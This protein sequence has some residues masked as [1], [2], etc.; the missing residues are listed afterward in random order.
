MVPYQ[1]FVPLKWFVV[2]HHQMPEYFDVSI[3]VPCADPSIPYCPNTTWYSTTWTQMFPTDNWLLPKWHLFQ[4]E[5]PDHKNNY[6]QSPR[7]IHRHEW[8]TS[9]LASHVVLHSLKIWLHFICRVQNGKYSNIRYEIPGTKTFKYRQSSDSG[10][11]FPIAL[12]CWM[13]E[14]PYP[15]ASKICGFHEAIGTG[16][17]CGRIL[18]II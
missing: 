15:N 13:H 10:P 8:K 2:D 11:E 18:F 16:A 17:W 7:K 14:F 12:D 9:P 3:S 1:H 5:N 6:C 4:L